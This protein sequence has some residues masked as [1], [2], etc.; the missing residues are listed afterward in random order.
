[1]Y[2]G[3]KLNPS[4]NLIL[5]LMT[6]DMV[7]RYCIFV[8]LQM[9]SLLLMLIFWVESVVANDIAA[10]CGA[11]NYGACRIYNIICF[12]TS[13]ACFLLVAFSVRD[14]KDQVIK[15]LIERYLAGLDAA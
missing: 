12:H 11:S 14:F 7:S 13:D 4:S 1:M 9:K 3:V 2:F 15:R 5:G 8:S 6:T 10:T